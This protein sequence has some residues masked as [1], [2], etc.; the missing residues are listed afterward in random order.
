[1]IGSAA[2]TIL[3]S[4]A[5]NCFTS[6]ATGM[7]ASLFLFNSEAIDVDVNDLG[8]LGELGDFAGHA[9]VEPHAQRDQQVAIARPP[10]W[11]TRRRAC[12]ACRG[13]ADRSLGNAPS[14]ITVMVHGNA[15]LLHELPQF[16]GWLRR[17]S[18]RRRR[19]SPAASRS[20]IAAAAWRI[21]SGLACGT[22]PHVAG[23]L[24]RHVPIGHAGAC[25]ECPWACR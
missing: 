10:S 5:R 21:C 3:L 4:S 16:G 9:V 6:P 20:L 17:K 7:C 11:R 24:H 12:R 1:M 25:S 2:S 19:K 14:P 22:L 18:R 8:V 23:N 13:R 15:R